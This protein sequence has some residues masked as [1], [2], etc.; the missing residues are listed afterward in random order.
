MI[1]TPNAS[2]GGIRR[3]IRVKSDSQTTTINTNMRNGYVYEI[4]AVAYRPVDIAY[5]LQ[6]VQ[7]VCFP[8]GDTPTLSSIKD[9]II[10]R[11]G[12]DIDITVSLASDGSTI[13]VKIDNCNGGDATVTYRPLLKIPTTP[14]N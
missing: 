12:N 1:Y 6:I 3:E 8:S 13:T 5:R 2:Y 7:A 9:D 10:T 4:M 14:A 11:A